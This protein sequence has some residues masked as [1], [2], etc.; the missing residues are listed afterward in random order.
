MSQRP[1]S[2][3]LLR[4]ARRARW[5]VAVLALALWAGA[6]A[7]MVAA[8]LAAP[9]LSFAPV[10]KQVAPS[11][12]TIFTSK[13]VKHQATQLP[14]GFDDPSMRR[15]FGIDPQ[16][17]GGGGG[18]AGQERDLKEQGLG[19]GVI[20]SADG[21]I[22]TN[23][24][25]VAEADELKVALSSGNE[26]YEAKVIG[27]DPKTDIAVLR[28]SVGH[29]L[30]AITLGDSAKAEVGDL[31]L[32]IGNPFNIGQTV[33][34]G[35]ISARGRGVGLADYEDFLQ[36]DASI[37]PG[38]SGGA[39]VDASGKLIG[40]NTAILSPS[41]GNLGIGF[42]VPINLARNVME[43]LVA[44][45]KVVR[46][47]LGLKIQ[48]VTADIAKAFS[49]PSEDG[50][51][52]GDVVVDGP[53][54]KAGIKSGDVVTAF[55]SIH[56]GDA[57]QLR[58]LASQTTPGTTVALN[59][60]RDGKPLNVSVTLQELSLAKGEPAD[61]DGSAHAHQAGRARLGVAL[62]DLDVPAREHFAVPGQIQGALIT[63]VV[64][65]SRA[66]NAGLKPGEVIMEVNRKPVASA[67]EAVA[68]IGESEGTVVLR[69]WTKE[70]IL[71]MVVH[72]P[73]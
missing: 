18:G 20:V 22:L 66:E 9:L 51:L 61:H 17:G 47:F 42:A 71:L 43:S 60:M 57:R 28:I 46:G 48:P 34:M 36:T 26:Q 25:V 62:S 1:P 53:S 58:L 40:I 30:P 12:V 65:G 23:N 37:N 24:H 31:V 67:S 68:A 7:S 59:V 49:L 14:P 64:P 19:S 39:L 44:K 33:T 69:M 8:D 41:G 72:A 10:V 32:A 29:L 38:N 5:L 6:Q 70:G 54:A 4:P 52:V 16:A 73:K 27:T 11:V 15:Y 13:T 56:I 21:I 35:I 55:N 63:E 2:P 50:A 45:G 3:S